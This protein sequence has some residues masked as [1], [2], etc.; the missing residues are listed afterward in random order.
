MDGTFNAAADTPPLKGILG[1]LDEPWA[2]ARIVD[3]TASSILDA[4]L[5]S[6]QDRDLVSVAAWY[7]NESGYSMRLAETIATMA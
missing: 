4:P 7:D 5:T 1:V 2:S 6:V 3:E